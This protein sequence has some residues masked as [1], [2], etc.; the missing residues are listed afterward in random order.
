MVIFPPSRDH[1]D[2]EIHFFY[3]ISSPWWSAALQLPPLAPCGCRLLPPW[4]LRHLRLADSRGGAARSAVRGP[5]RTPPASADRRPHAGSR[6]LPREPPA[7]TTAHSRA[8][9]TAPLLRSR[10]PGAPKL[11]CP[12][13]GRQELR[14]AGGTFP[15]ERAFRAAWGQAAGGG[16]AASRRSQSWCGVTERG[17]PSAAGNSRWRP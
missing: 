16:G 17:P 2:R 13:A 1:P 11:S 10:A 5:A 7:V 3:P 14:A 6:S 4:P 8:G 9:R 15:G 12:P